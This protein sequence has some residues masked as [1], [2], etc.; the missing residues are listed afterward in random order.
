MGKMKDEMQENNPLLQVYLKI[1]PLTVG[2]I[3]VIFVLVKLIS[4]LIA[5]DQ[6]ILTAK[7]HDFEKGAV[8]REPIKV[9]KDEAFTKEIKQK[10]EKKS[11]FTD[12]L[13]IIEGGELEEEKPGIVS[14]DGSYFFVYEN[15]KIPETIYVKSPEWWQPVLFDEEQTIPLEVGAKINLVQDSSP[16]A[17]ADGAFEIKNIETTKISTGIFNITVTMTAAGDAVPSNVR[18]IMGEEVFKEWDGSSE[19]VYNKETGFEE[20]TLVFRYNRSLREDISDL[21]EGA[22]VAVEEYTVRR[23][24][25]EAEITANIGGVEIVE[26]E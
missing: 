25:K 8:L 1:L 15:T 2:A 7:Y 21:L 18:L 14:E 17:C 11:G 20:R 4:G 3:A 5:P 12:L 19:L 26:V 6:L 22:V 13:V 16:L 24:F 23:V 10:T 9:A